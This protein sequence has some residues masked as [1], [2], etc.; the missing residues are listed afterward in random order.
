MENHKEDAIGIT[1]VDEGTTSKAYYCVMF[2]SGIIIEQGVI[3]FMPSDI[4]FK[5]ICAMLSNR[6]NCKVY[7]EKDG[8]DTVKY[9]RTSYKYLRL[10]EHFPKESFAVF[11][12]EQ[13]QKQIDDIV[14]QKQEFSK[15]FNPHLGEKN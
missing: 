12:H 9:K 5:E 7:V 1:R 8:S 2:E 11:N 6:F 13:L 14:E 10:E 3:E 4:H 15:L